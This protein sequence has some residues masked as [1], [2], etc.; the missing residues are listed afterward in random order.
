ME[1]DYSAGDQDDGRASSTTPTPPTVHSEL[2]TIHGMGM[3]MVLDPT[4]PGSSYSPPLRHSLNDADSR[5]SL[6]E[7]ELFRAERKHEGRPFTSPT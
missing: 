2:S 4:K 1:S 6:D 5:R 7:T 3:A